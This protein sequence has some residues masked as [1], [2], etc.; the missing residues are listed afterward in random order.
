[1][2]LEATELASNQGPS[3]GPRRFLE[4]RGGAVVA[5]QGIGHDHHL[6]GVRRVLNLLLVSRHAG[7]DDH[8]AARLNG[9]AAAFAMERESV[10]EQEH[11]RLRHAASPVP[12]QSGYG[13]S[14][15]RCVR[16]PAAQQ[17]ACSFLDS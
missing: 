2:L 4:I 8:L 11:H 6:A 12:S 7:V 14:S 3:P 9:L 17:T 16:A 5:D 1:M 15:S 10:L 13:T